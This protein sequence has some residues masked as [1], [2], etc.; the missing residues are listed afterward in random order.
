MQLTDMYW[1]LGLEL[2]EALSWEVI[3]VRMN[4]GLYSL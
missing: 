1:G 2:G 3:Q 4:A